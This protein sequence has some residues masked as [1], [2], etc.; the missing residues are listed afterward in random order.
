LAGVVKA[1]GTTVAVT[2][3][4]GILRLVRIGSTLTV[5]YWKASTSSW[6]SITCG[7]S[8]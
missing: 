4:V 2:D 7:A 8:A 3:T 6:V 5:Y 1:S